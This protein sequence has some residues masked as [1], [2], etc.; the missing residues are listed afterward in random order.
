VI[1]RRAGRARPSTSI[2]CSGDEG[3]GVNIATGRPRSVMV[4]VSPAAA[5]ATTADAFCLR[6]RIPTSLTC[7]N[8]AHGREHG[9][10]TSTRPAA[11]D[12]SRDA[13]GSLPG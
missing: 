6:A 11:E 7:F 9:I 8:V 13:N 4:T 12:E 10:A 5:L 3:S 1:D 2:V